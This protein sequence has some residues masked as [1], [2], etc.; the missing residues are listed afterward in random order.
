MT[1]DSVSEFRGKVSM[2]VKGSSYDNADG[3]IETNN[4]TYK[5]QDLS[6]NFADFEIMSSFRGKE[7]TIS[8]NSPDIINGEVSGQ[9]KIVDILKLAENSV[10]SIYTN[11]VAYEVEEGQYLNFRFNIYSKIAAVFYKDLI[12]GNNTFIEGRMETDKT[13]FELTFNSP[14]IKFQD[15]F[16][17][18][19]F[20]FHN[21]VIS[22]NLSIKLERH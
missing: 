13:G 2:T 21:F 4:T 18:N 7:R 11:Y 22:F 5:N 16:A 1:R 6:Y 17:N 3:I 8:I 19:N 12:L 9:F 10:G 15:Y 20:N 14:E